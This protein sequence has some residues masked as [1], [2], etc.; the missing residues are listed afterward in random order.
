M[1]SI[2]SRSFFYNLSKY[3]RQIQEEK[4]TPRPWI[5]RSQDNCRW[6]KGASLT[7]SQGSTRARSQLSKPIQERPWQVQASQY[8]GW[9]CSYCDVSR[10]HWALS[11]RIICSFWKAT[12]FFV[13][14][15]FFSFIYRLSKLT[16]KNFSF[17]EFLTFEKLLKKR[18]QELH[19]I[20]EEWSQNS[21]ASQNV[22]WE[23]FSPRENLSF[24]ICSSRMRSQ[25][26]SDTDDAPSSSPQKWLVG[27][28]IAT[29]GD[30]DF[31]IYRFR[32]LKPE[33]RKSWIVPGL[34]PYEGELEG[35]P[36][37]TSP[38]RGGME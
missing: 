25:I 10:T 35:I 6:S 9:K 12:N 3:G 21:I 28:S 11:C 38:M 8:C 29:S 16:S 30:E 24:R 2:E 23:R 5:S 20:I 22:N 17:L 26:P 13:R 4:E 36:H 34:S 19:T 27:V 18:L 1:F 7:S 15:K 33:N 32:T 31:M 14:E 37:L